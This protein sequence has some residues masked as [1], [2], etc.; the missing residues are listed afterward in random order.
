MHDQKISLV[1]PVRDEAA[2]IRM[3]IDS[4]GRQT[5]PPDEVIIVDGGSSDA[6]VSIVK[7]LAEHQENLRL[8]ETDGATPG[9]GRNLG[10]E[11]ASN[12]W[13]ALTDAGIR[14]EDDWLKHLAG[15]SADADLVLGNYAPVTDSF[16]SR[17]AALAYVPAQ[18]PQAIRGR[19][20]ASSLIRKETWEKAGRFPDLRAAEDLIFIENVEKIGARIAYAPRAVVHWQLRPDVASTFAKFV[21]YSHHN[22]LAGRQWDWHYGVLKQYAL[23][24]LFI[25]LA[26]VHSGWWLLAIPC[27][28]AARTAKRIFPFREEYGIARLLNP[29]Q[30][31]FTAFLI[32][33]IDIATFVGWIQAAFSGER[34]SD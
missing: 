32:I 29:M 23:L 15:A 26:V 25:V 12:E 4:I 8:I 33:L 19:F 24:F 14:I 30:F 13:V 3:L 27:W 10:I 20:I 1:I 17:C 2:S 21:L 16:F 34:A 7:E 31:A 9:R 11:A 22:V 6:T 28:I 5:L 18:R